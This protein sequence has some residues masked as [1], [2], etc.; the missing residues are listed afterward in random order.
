MDLFG[1]VS[2]AKPFLKWAGGKR[3]LIP[4]IQAIL[5]ATLAQETDLTYVEPFIG[6]GAVLFWMLQQYPN[7][8]RAVIND[9]NPDLTT[10]YQVV[11][12]R[13]EELIKALNTIQEFYYKLGTEDARRSYFDEVRAEFNQ[14]PLAPLRNTVALIFLNRTCFNGLYRVNSKG[15]FNVPFG[16]YDR[17]SI[18][19]PTTIRADSALLARVTILNGDFTEVLPHVS[20]NSLFYFDPPY[21]PLSKTA[22]FNA[23]ATETFDDGA[24]CRLAEFCRNLDTRGYRWLLSNSDVQNTD[25]GNSY[26]DDLYAGFAL[27]RVQAKRTINSKAEGRGHI[28]ELLINNYAL[29]DMPQLA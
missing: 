17:P 19:N 4:T 10:A 3:Q 7:I 25:S 20:A 28:S 29:T 12:Q 2:G 8:R 26:F 16:R 5:P 24:Q 18:C 14:R 1:E 6:G 22:L 23:Y 9:I 27:Q 11:Q 13:P 15:G 21:K